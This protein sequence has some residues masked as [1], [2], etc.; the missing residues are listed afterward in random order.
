VTPFDLANDDVLLAILAE[1]LD[2]ADPVPTGAL[3]A[4]KAMAQL[5]DA[6]VE[7][8]MLVADSLLDDE[9]LLFRH[10]VTME[11]E[12]EPSDRLISFATPALHVDVDLQAN[13]GSMVGAISPAMSVAVELETKDA[14]ISTT[15]DDLGRFHLEA[16]RGRCRLRIHAHGGAVVTPWI[17]R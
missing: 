12:G 15:S 9:V 11:P 7:L 10:D 3:A 2:E 1:S 13:G 17:T 8:A 16:P 6:D 14:T 5:A 4:A